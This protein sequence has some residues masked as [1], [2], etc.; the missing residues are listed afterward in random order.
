VRHPSL[1]CVIDP[2]AQIA[3][4]LTGDVDRIVAAVRVLSRVA[5]RPC[6]REGEDR[7]L[8]LRPPPPYNEAVPQLTRAQIV[9]ALERLDRALGARGTRAE[10]YLVGG[11]VMCLVLD[12]RAS[13]KDVD[14]WFTE[15]QA[16]RAAAREVA[17]DMGLPD[18]WLNDA[19]K[20]F[21]PSGAAFERWRALEHLDISVADE[22][23]LLAMKC[24]AAR[25]EEDA[26][27]IRTLAARLGLTSAAAVLTEVERFYPADRLGVRTRLLVE[28]MFDDRR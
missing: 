10:L 13:T 6:A 25:T 1:V 8:R 15:P 16:V 4:V 26:R 21:I 28:E 18:D 23:T 22:R 12:A 19:A 5:V 24:A 17:G 7:K 11:A 27:D 14:G 9:E 20:A 3:Y 2:A